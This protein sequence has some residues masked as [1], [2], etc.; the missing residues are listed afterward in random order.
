MRSLPVL[1]LL[2]LPCAAEVAPDRAKA[3]EN[4]V[5]QDCGSCHGMTLKGGLGRPLTRA[6]L[7]HAEAEGLASIILDGVSGTAM[8]PWRPLLNEDEALWIA[9]YLK[10]D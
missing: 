1:L 6:A 2:A 10:K 4:M 5:L 3:L 7:A 9:H 8:P